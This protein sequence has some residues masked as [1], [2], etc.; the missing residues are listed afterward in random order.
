MWGAPTALWLLE[1]PPTLS[2][3]FAHGL[4]LRHSAHTSR[5]IPGLHTHTRGAGAP[6]PTCTELLGEWKLPPTRP[7]LPGAQLLGE[8]PQP[9]VSAWSPFP[10]WRP[11]GGTVPWPRPG[12][13]EVARELGSGGI[14][15]PHSAL[16]NA[17]AFVSTSELSWQFPK[18]PS[19]F[20]CAYVEVGHR[21]R[22]SGSLGGCGHPSE[23]QACYLGG[24]EGDP[25]QGALSRLPQATRPGLLHRGERGEA[26]KS[27]GGPWGT[28]GRNLQQR[29][30]G[31]PCPAC[32]L[33]GDTV[34]EQET[35]HRPG[36]RKKNIFPCRPSLQKG[37]NA[38]PDTVQS[39][40][41]GTPALRA[42]HTFSLRS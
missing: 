13:S 14:R 4:S 23:S 37:V 12:S 1:P 36:R 28:E 35:E 10:A 19:C 33:R 7:P 2:P 34:K 3:Q 42:S 17:G 41:R 29:A 11:P 15:C 39:S 16:W 25:G 38:L 21:T 40:G 24:E 8:Q 27:Q 31:P 20:L 26:D 30:S 9:R 18:D 5:S 22:E 32:S 6:E